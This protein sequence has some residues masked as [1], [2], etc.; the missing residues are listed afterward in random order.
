M[1][2]IF[3]PLIVALMALVACNREAYKTAGYD[4]YAS[5]HR[6]MAILPTETITTGRMP[7]DATAEDI[8]V[9]EEAESKAFQV[10]LY[11]QL[12]KRSGKRDGDIRINFQH[13]SETNALLEKAG[14]NLRDSWKHSPVELAG[15]L[16]VDAIVRTTVRKEFYLT[17]LESFGIQ[18]ATTIVAIFA[19]PIA[20]W[21]FPNAHTSEVF[22]SCSVLDGKTGQPTWSISRDK[23]T[24]WNKSHSE[25]VE[26]ITRTL[27]RRFSYRE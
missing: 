25:V 7:K 10:A 12:S 11:N 19:D 8:A 20:W 23:P 14:I 13:Y 26:E 16:G 9:V 27:S 6:T 3:V 5:T 18:V 15:L 21:L 2:K 24:Y 4:E 1:K 17:N 22:A